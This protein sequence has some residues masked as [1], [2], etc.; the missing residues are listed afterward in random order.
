VTASQDQAPLRG[1]IAAWI[2]EASE[3]LEDARARQLPAP[4]VLAIGRRAFATAGLASIW[5]DENA[6]ARDAY[7]AA[8]HE[9]RRT[10]PL[11][12]Q[13]LGP[14]LVRRYGGE[15]RT[16]GIAQM[17][18]D[19][20]AELCL[21]ND[22]DIEVIARAMTSLGAA[23]QDALVSVAANDAIPP[24]LRET[25]ARARPAAD[26]VWSHYGGDSGGW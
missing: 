1:R 20:S 11:L 26:T 18:S 21:S 12:D 13:A 16:A 24:A 19:A 8:D 4:V 5:L 9:C 25:A 15:T 23:L 14:Q 22:A 10:L 2:R 17:S 7:Q 6:P 3:A